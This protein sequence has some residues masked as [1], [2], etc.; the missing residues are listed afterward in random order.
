MQIF[1]S[2]FSSWSKTCPPTLR[3]AFIYGG[4]DGMIS[5]ILGQMLRLFLQP[6][7]LSIAVLRY[8]YKILK[9]DP[10]LL[11]DEWSTQPL[12]VSNKVIVVENC[13]ESIS[14]DLKNLL[15]INQEKAGPM[16]IF[17]AGEVKKNSNIVATLAK[18][19]N[20]V[21]IPCYKPDAASIVSYIIQWFKD[22]NIQYEQ[23][24]P[25]AIAELMPPDHLAVRN[26]LN[27]LKLYI[28]QQFLS[29][30]DVY[31]VFIND[32][33]L[34]LDA[35][36]Y[37]FCMRNKSTI[38]KQLS[39]KHDLR[40]V[41]LCMLILR[42]LQ[43]YLMK[44]IQIREAL[45]SGKS[46][47][48]ALSELHPPVFFKHKEFVLKAAQ[49]LKASQLYALLRY[50]VKLEGRIKSLKIDSEQLLSFSLLTFIE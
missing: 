28:E 25:L 33:E 32:S 4:D 50:I 18:L 3:F 40:G 14:S 44:L 13:T 37:A 47:E 35:L 41:P 15:K 29:L 46:P 7:E 21:L 49:K 24:V 34:S 6:E 27:K 5:I 42:A 30:Q 26:E 20:T 16:T 39:K 2:K 12:F 31:H 1:P 9:E 19:E 10:S 43:N 11:S 36:C 48:I 45:D 38:T 8:D 23:G 17:V 22:N